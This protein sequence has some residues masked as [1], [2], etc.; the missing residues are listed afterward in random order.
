M[1]NTESIERIVAANGDTAERLL[2][3]CGELSAAANKLAPSQYASNSAAVTLNG[4]GIM[5]AVLAVVA[6]ISCTIA[7]CGLMLTSRDYA[8]LQREVDQLRSD[9]ATQQIYIT[10][11]RRNQKPKE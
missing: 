3:A 1:T 2:Q 4:G 10:E 9:V 6:I 8:N 5:A 11:F 7:V